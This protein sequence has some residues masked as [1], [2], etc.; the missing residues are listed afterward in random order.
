[1]SHKENDKY[2]ENKDEFLAEEDLNELGVIM[3]RLHSKGVDRRVI[4]D[5]IINAVEYQDITELCGHLDSFLRS[6]KF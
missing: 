1:M 6:K 5:Q 2:N 4:A 3:A